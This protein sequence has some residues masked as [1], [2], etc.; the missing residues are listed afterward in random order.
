VHTGAR[1]TKPGDAG[2]TGDGGA[3]TDCE[4]SERLCGNGEL[5]EDE[6]EECDDG[7][8]R[9]GDGCSGI[10]TLEPNY[11]CPEPGERCV[12][13]LRCG[14]G[15]LGGQEHCD[16]GNDDSGDGCSDECVVEPGWGCAK[17]G[18]PC[19][20]VQTAE[21]GDGVVNAGELCDDGNTNPD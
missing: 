20:P 3:C 21:C 9:A 1:T 6:G 12:S 14:D 11:E 17:P 4:P 7:N 10:C 8:A 13:T 15:V 18:E 19:R 16:D 5:D 2:G